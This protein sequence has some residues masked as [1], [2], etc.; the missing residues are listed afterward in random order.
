[1]PTPSAFRR[2]L[3]VPGEER[4]WSKE[5]EIFRKRIVSLGGHVHSEP[6]KST[7]HILTAL[8]TEDAVRDALGVDA[9]PLGAVVVRK[10]WLVESLRELRALPTT[11]YAVPRA[12]GQ[13]SG[14]A[15]AAWLCLLV[16]AVCRLGM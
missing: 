13:Q 12:E 5:L 6:S 8:G 2:H 14:P 7:T 9:L 10:E 16:S 3:C 1:M 15:G 11:E 4:H